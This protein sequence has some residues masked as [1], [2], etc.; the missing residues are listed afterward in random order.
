M[1]S[2]DDIFNGFRNGAALLYWPLTI[3]VLLPAFFAPVSC[4]SSNDRTSE[5]STTAP[6]TQQETKRLVLGQRF[7]IV[8]L[9]DLVGTVKI[10]PPGALT[11]EAAAAG[12]PIQEGFQLFSSDDSSASVIFEDNSTAIIGPHSHVIFHQLGRDSNGNRLTGLTLEHGLTTFHFLPQHHVNSPKDLSGPMEST[13]KDWQIGEFLEVHI[14][15]ARMTT[16]SKCLF[17]ADFKGAYMRVEV[18]KGQLHFS[19]PFQS[20]NLSSGKSIEHRVGGTETT[21]KYHSKIAKDP[22]DGFASLEEEKVLSAPKDKKNHQP[23]DV[24]TIIRFRNLS[25]STS[26]G[27]SEPRPPHGR[28]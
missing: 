22:W 14:A 4:L 11:D 27:R 17:R 16:K 18:F 2:R 24:N 8:D 1:L 6:A 26:D 12:M 15:D 20:V 10:R 19:T 9:G 5:N 25:P 23:E 13:V 28:Y 3:L 21:F 7:R